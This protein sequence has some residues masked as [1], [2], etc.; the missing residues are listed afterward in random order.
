MTREEA[1]AKLRP[2]EDELRARG[3][4]ALY[5]FGSVARDEAR[6]ESDV[7]VMCRFDPA[8]SVTLFDFLGFEMD[9]QDILGCEVDLSEQAAMPTRMAERVARDA[10]RVF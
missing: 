1:L 3:I 5:L 9:F 4:E 10:V 6:P 8:R 7:D 2:M